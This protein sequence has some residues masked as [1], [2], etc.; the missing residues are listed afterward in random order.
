[1]TSYDVIIIGGG[2][3]GC[4]LANR[5]SENPNTSVCLLE[6]GPADK[7]PAIHIPFGLA[8]MSELK[9]INWQLDTAK[10]PHLNNRSLFWPRGK[11]LGG[12]SS[13]NAMCYIRGNKNNYDEWASI[14]AEGWAW[15]DV[16]PYFRKSENNT[17]GISRLHGCGGPQ[18]VS[19]LKHINPL[20]REFIEAAKRI[21][22][23]ENPDFNGISQE[24]VGF[25]Q[26][27]HRDGA[28]SSTAKAYLSPKVKARDNLT[29]MTEATAQRLL[30]D[31]KQVTGV[32]ATVKGKQL[33]LMANTRVFVCA[34][35]VHSPA[36]LLASGIGPKDTLDAVNIEQIHELSGVGKNLHDHLDATIVYKQN[37]STSYGLSISGIIKNA[38]EPIKYWR[39]RSGMLSSNIAE[40]GA[41]F[42][43]SPDKK[44]PDIQI[45]FLPALLIDHGRT[46]PWG[47]GFTIHFCNLYPKSR[48]EV[49]LKRNAEGELE[50][51][52]YGNYLAEPEDMAPMVA[53]FKWARKVANA[54]PLQNQSYEMLPGDNVKTDDDIEAF[55]R[56]HAETVYHP[57]GT[58]KMGTEDDNFAVVNSELE[59][60]GIDGLSVVDASV[61]PRLIGGN[62]NA[63]TI[64][65]AEKASDMFLTKQAQQA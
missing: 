9:S 63:P 64:M 15:D 50:V 40:A 34:G 10:E 60:I 23:A 1:M 58:C 56:Q 37:R 2:S 5:L 65:I 13:I 41:F 62:T 27:T 33:T 7:H 25:Y 30:L 32:L 11:T 14:G 52:I 6:A 29:I 55:I 19:D 44:L 31:N 17:R 18:D 12:S 54:Q 61:M 38:L 51:D 48:G 46:K 20:S 16:L 49:K 28:R 21:G 39:S 45:H 42:K 43:S 8:L 35:A 24:G 22:T 57:A 3:A 53:G 26:V 4:V 59:V 47:H 36:L